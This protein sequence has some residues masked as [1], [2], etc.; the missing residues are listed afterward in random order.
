MMHHKA[1]LPFLNNYSTFHTSYQFIIPTK[2]YTKP[3]NQHK[4]TTAPQPKPKCRHI[5]IAVNICCVTGFFPLIRSNSS[6]CFNS[7]PASSSPTCGWVFSVTPMSVCPIRYCSVFRVHARLR[8]VRT[9]CIP[10]Y[11]RGYAGHLYSVDLIVPG[12]HVIGEFDK[13]WYSILERWLIELCLKKS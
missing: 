1:N 6:M 7:S 8:H 9:V 4:K 13:L 12:D 11:V 10:A 5:H 2:I 3:W